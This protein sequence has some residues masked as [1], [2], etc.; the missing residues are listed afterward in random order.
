MKGGNGEGVSPFKICSPV[1]RHQGIDR[2]VDFPLKL[3]R[4]IAG[5]ASGQ[6]LFN[7]IGKI[8]RSQKPLIG[9]YNIF[10]ILL[11]YFCTNPFFAQQLL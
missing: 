2:F 6:F 1:E 3:N 10:I 7:L 4:I 11:F 9:A 8:R 5:E